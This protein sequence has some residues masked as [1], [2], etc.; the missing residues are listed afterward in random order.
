MPTLR[1]RA[2]ISALFLRLER[3][4]LKEPFNINR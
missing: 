2:D 1:H 3:S 4:F